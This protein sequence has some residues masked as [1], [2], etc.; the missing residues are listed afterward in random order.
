MLDRTSFIGALKQGLKFQKCSEFTTLIAI[1]EYIYGAA[2][3]QND[4]EI[5]ELIEQFE[6]FKKSKGESQHDKH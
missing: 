4:K 5:L 2:E 6:M 1:L 3:Y